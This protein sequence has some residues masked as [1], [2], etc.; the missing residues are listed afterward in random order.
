M[1]Q[2]GYMM[3][4]IGSA[5]YG[6]EQGLGFTAS[7]FHLFTHA[8]FKALLFLAA[9]AV[10]HYVHNNDMSAMGGLRKQLPVTHITFLVA[11]LSIAGFPPFAGFFSKEE[12]LLAAHQHHQFI[13]WIA[14]ITSGLTAFYIFRLYFNIFWNRTP[15]GPVP[16]AHTH[17]EGGWTILLPLILLAAGAAFAGFIPFG[18]FV[19]S[20]GASL[21]TPFHPEFAIAPVSFSLA[22]IFLAMWLYRKQNDRSDRF[23]ASIKGVYR[24]AYHKF[25]V[26]EVYLFI[27]RKLIFNLIGKPAAWIDK[28]VVDGLVNATGYTTQAISEKIKGVQSGKVQAYA[29]YFLAGAIGLALLFIYG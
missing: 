9:G 16:D 11:C 2:I 3:F 15:I 10:I 21:A 29:I 23:V 12:I 24:F 13:Y 27:T 14:L 19:S 20:D 28:N 7:M 18:H 4:A 6:G 22:G 8:M 5:N 25:Y 1:S 17:G 26:D